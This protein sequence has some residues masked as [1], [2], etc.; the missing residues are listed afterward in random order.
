MAW[1][2]DVLIHLEQPRKGINNMKQNFF[3]CDQ[4]GKFKSV[5]CLLVFLRGDFP[6]VPLDDTKP[7]H[8]TTMEQKYIIVMHSLIDVT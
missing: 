4:P 8:V 6:A 3:Q 1:P 5:W 2:T 7:K